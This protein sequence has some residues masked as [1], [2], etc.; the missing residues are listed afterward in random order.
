MRL[1]LFTAAFGARPLGEV[2]RWAAGAGF[3][4]LEVH[5]PPGSK[6]DLEVELEISALSYYP[7]NLDP[8]DGAREAAHARVHEL[9]DAAAALGVG[10][11]CTFAGADPAR[12]LDENLDRFRE[13]WPPLVAHAEE[14]GVRIAIESCPMVHER[15][16][17]PGGTNLAYCPAA[18]EAMFDAIPS[19]ALGLNLDP[20]H[21]HWLGIDLGRAVR[22]HGE[23]I[24][25]VHAKDTEID[26][27]ELYRRS[28]LSLGVGW[29]QGRMPGRGEIDWAA[30]VG[31]LRDVGYDGV[32]SVEHEDHGID[33]EPGF[34]VA[35][36]TLRPLL[37]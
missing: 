29:Q 14:R 10:L 9:I 33:L 26:R 18:W 7:N 23:R 17:W 20:S 8:D 30:F 27:D 32:L 25:H 12:P 6:L 2:A 16:R 1:G 36:D 4:A 5:C 22:D 3:E 31:A 11:V 24:F 35:R 21:L 28:I 19:A 34:E 37:S 15:A 13:L